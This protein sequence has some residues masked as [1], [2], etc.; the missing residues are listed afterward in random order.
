MKRLK[1]KE[2][3]KRKLSREIEDKQE[4]NE[5]LELRNIIMEIKK[6]LDG[7]NRVDMTDERMRELENRSI[8]I[9]HLEKQK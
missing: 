4:L 1:K 5:N 9:I 3:K 8:E 7:L 6:L 2:R